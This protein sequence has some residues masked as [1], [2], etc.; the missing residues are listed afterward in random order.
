M[1]EISAATAT[2]TPEQSE[3]GQPTVFR[4]GRA[5]RIIFSFLFILLLPFFVSLGP[6]LFW[7]LAQG[8][9][10]GTIGLALMAICFAALMLLIFIE[11]LY[12]IRTEVVFGERAVRLTLPSGRGPTPM[13]RYQT[14]TIPYE[15]VEAVE[16]RREVYGYRV[17]PVKMKG[18]R[19][20]LKDG[21]FVKLGYIN[22]ANVDPSVPI[23]EIAEMIAARAGAPIE[24]A[25]H[26]Y[27]SF[28]D[29]LLGKKATGE[30]LK[31]IDAAEITQINHK[32]NNFLLSLVGVLVVLTLLGIVSDRDRRLDVGSMMGLLSSQETQE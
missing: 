4:A 5:R 10:L 13:L 23:M 25:G 19:L 16:V 3:P 8:H 15:D 18:A 24:D 9:M 17:A 6:M 22:E 32:H 11:L 2:G 12:S 14:R 20:R 27:R 30:Q 1:A 26:V 29:K 21:S 31:P 28:R 7:R